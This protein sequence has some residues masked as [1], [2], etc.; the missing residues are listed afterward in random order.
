M[1]VKEVVTNRL[2]DKIFKRLLNGKNNRYLHDFIN[3]Q[4]GIGDKKFYIVMCQG[5]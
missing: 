2:V 1:V 4:I 3:I 5:D